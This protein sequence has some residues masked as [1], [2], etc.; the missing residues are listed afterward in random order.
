MEE[1][2]DIEIY[3]KRMRKAMQDKMWWIS[4]VDVKVVV[5]YGCA[6]GTLLKFVHED[7]PD[8][9]LIGVD[10]NQSMLDLARKNVPNALFFTTEEFFNIN[11]NFGN[12]VLILSSVIHEIYSYEANPKQTMEQLLSK[13]FKYVA[14]RDMFVRKELKTTFSGDDGETVLSVADQKQ[15]NDFERV[16][17]SISNRQ[18]MI[19]YLL[20][21]KYIENWAREVEE[22]YFPFSLEDFVQYVLSGEYQIEYLNHYTL[23]FIRDQIQKDFGFALTDYTHLKLLLK[24]V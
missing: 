17:G 3:N 2:K 8:L 11:V 12:A 10:N 16:W 24:R 15:L 5:D 22:N 13:S 19:H 14:I 1:I 9:I 23:P 21:Y 20:K 18:N 7:R 4:M 6:D